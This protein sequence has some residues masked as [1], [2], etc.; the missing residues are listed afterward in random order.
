MARQKMTDAQK[1]NQKDQHAR[2]L[3]KTFDRL[4]D[5]VSEGAF[6]LSDPDNLELFLVDVR[7]AN[8]RIEKIRDNG[9]DDNAADN[10]GKRL[11]PEEKVQAAEDRLYAAHRRLETIFEGN[12]PFVLASP[13]F[14]MAVKEFKG[15]RKALD[16]LQETV[17]A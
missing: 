17:S 16:K 9:D 5:S 1:Q 12:D 3:Q 13:D 14:D 8:E 11:T 10:K 4:A 6:T 15:A 2:I 7:N